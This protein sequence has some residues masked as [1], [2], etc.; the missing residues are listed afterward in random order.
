MRTRRFLLV[1]RIFSFCMGFVPL[2]EAPL[3]ALSLRDGF[4]VV[5][6]ENE[7][8]LLFLDLSSVLPCPMFLLHVCL[9]GTC[10]T[11]WVVLDALP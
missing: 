10:S 9:H 5:L 4:L 1:L 8:L 11:P 6:A 7:S 2:S 3:C